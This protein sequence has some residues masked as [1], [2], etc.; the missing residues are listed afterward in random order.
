MK[1][2]QKRTDFNRKTL[3][4]VG[5][6]HQRK[7]LSFQKDFLLEDKEQLTNHRRGVDTK[8]LI[9]LPKVAELRKIFEPKRKE[10]LEMKRKERIA[11]RLEGIESDAQPILLQSCTGL[12]TH[13]LLEE[14]TPR[15]MRATDPASPHIGEQGRSNEEE[16]TSDSSL[17]KQTQSKHCTE[18]SGIHGDSSCG[19]GTMDTQGLESKAER[20]A[21]YKAE[22]RRQLAEKYGLTLDSEADSESPAR[23]AKSRK[24]PD[25]D[26]CG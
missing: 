26:L 22:R 11:R 2:E 7:V 4:F 20:I 10:F 19:S 18:T 15:Y 6:P 3:S 16:D 9:V 17:E 21:R 5:F 24:D 14:D 1:R 13:R 25:A 8:L 23:Y 12:V